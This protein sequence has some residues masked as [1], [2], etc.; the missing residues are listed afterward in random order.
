MAKDNLKR[1]K[2]W[3]TWP[4]RF[5]GMSVFPGET[6]YQDASGAVFCS[7]RHAAKE[8]A[9]QAERAMERKAAERTRARQQAAEEPRPGTSCGS[10]TSSS[11]R[12][13]G[14]SEVNP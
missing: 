4:C 12:P 14:R 2:A 5:C 10:A 7:P 9:F 8:A 1:L 13:T 11:S 6:A 3:G